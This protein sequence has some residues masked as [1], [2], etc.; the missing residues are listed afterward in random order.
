MNTAVRYGVGGATVVAVLTLMLSATVFGF[1]VINNCG[2]SQ[3]YVDVL[4]SYLQRAYDTYAQ[5]IK[6][7]ALCPDFRVVL[8]NDIQYPAV[9]YSRIGPFGACV[10]KMEFRCDISR[11]WLQHLAFHEMAHALQSA[12]GDG[13]KGYGWWS[14]AHAEGLASY[15]MVERVYRVGQWQRYG[16]VQ[17][18]WDRRL[19]RQDP[20]R[21][22]A[23]NLC[24][25]Q[26]GAFFAWLAQQYS[27]LNATLTYS[28]PHDKL[29]QVYWNFLL[30]PWSWGRDPV[31]LDFDRCIGVG[32]E[33]NTALY[34]VY[35][36][37]L[38]NRVYVFSVPS[39]LIINA[40]GLPDRILL[41]LVATRQT[42]ADPTVTV[43]YCP[44]CPPATTIT[45]TQTVTTTRTVT[46]TH[47]VTRTTTVTVPTTYTTTVT[48]PV[49]YTVTY[50][51]PVTTTVTVTVPITTTYTTTT[52][53]TQT[54]PITFTVPITTTVTE[55]VTQ[56]AP[57]TVTYTETV[58]TSVVNTTTVTATVSGQESDRCM[59][60]FYVVVVAI[61][62]VVAC[63]AR[64]RNS[65]KRFKGR[66]FAIYT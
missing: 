40:T 42:T 47:T 14:E 23:P 50:T 46:E 13:G 45:T 32:M 1:T 51:I 17:D 4:V 8:R 3:D 11:A 19:Y 35:S 18:F 62:I 12:V 48:V 16:W 63:L 61:I 52:T 44:E 9:T 30:S 2:A 26:Y 53:V 21:C 27:P 39:P 43:S 57:V 10:Y 5:E 29:R 38:P 37:T 24:A 33:R 28:F 25:Y 6:T 41:A 59:W 15:Y 7:P 36:P 60:C 55:T 20:W 64:C 31:Y 22:E 54:V 49:T 65:T 66:G 34:C 56:T 58:T